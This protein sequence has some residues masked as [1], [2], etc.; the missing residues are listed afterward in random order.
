[1]LKKFT[2]QENFWKGKFGDKY[3]L[4]NKDTLL[5]TKFW[6]M[7]LKKVKIKNIYELG[8]NAGP[9]LDAIKLVDK[10]IETNGIEINKKGHSICLKKGHNIENGSIVE[11]IKV[12]KKFDLVFTSSV[13][14]HINPDKLEVVYKNINTLSKKYVLINEYHS[15]FPVEVKYRGHKNMLFKRDFAYEIQ[16]KYNYKLVDYGFLWKYDKN[17]FYPDLNWFLFKKK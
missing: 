14:I 15:P 2:P 8:P 3:I 16:K 17:N 1:M 4:R 9:N 7:I 10:K 12:K 11:K 5:R 13:L 6:K